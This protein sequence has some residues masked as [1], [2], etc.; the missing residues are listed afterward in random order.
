M[1]IGQDEMQIFAAI[2]FKELLRRF[3]SINQRPDGRKLNQIRPVTVIPDPL[4][5]TA[6]SATVGLGLTRVLAGCNVEPGPMMPGRPGEGRVQITC[7]FGSVSRQSLE[8]RRAREKEQ[9]IAAFLLRTLLSSKVI[10]LTQLSIRESSAVLVLCIDIVATSDDGNLLDASLVAVM[11]AL[12]TAQF[13][14]FAVDEGGAVVPAP[15]QPRWRL[16]LRHY[17]FS[18][19]FG[20]FEKAILHDCTSKEEQELTGSFTVVYNNAGQLC[21]LYKPGGTPVPREAL[22]ECMGVAKLHAQ[23]TFQ[24]LQT[25]VRV[26]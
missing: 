15:D 17:P 9:A 11:G 7:S 13:P 25:S 22:K 6:G 23:R 24:V 4:S 14:Q 12:R 21:G 26:T 5:T 18:L 8:Q 10:D 19:S 3:V 2:H 20:L 1:Q 16:A